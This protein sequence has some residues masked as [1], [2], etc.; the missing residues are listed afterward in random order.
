MPATQADK[1]VLAIA[2]FA[3]AVVFRETAGT[4]LRHGDKETVGDLAPHVEVGKVGIRRNGFKIHV[5]G[6]QRRAG[7]DRVLLLGIVAVGLAGAF[8]LGGGFLVGLCGSR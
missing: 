6:R 8:L 4:H 2:V 3:H 1:A 5:D 7:V